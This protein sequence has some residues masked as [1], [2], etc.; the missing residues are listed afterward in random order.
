[1]VATGSRA[2]LDGGSGDFGMLGSMALWFDSQFGGL[3]EW[4]RRAE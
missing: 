2:N 1:L 4:N 3:P